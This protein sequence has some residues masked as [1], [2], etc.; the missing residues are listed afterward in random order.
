[1]KVKTRVKKSKMRDFSRFS[2]DILNADLSN[3]DWS[4]LFANDSNDVNSIFSSF[5]NKFNKLVN[6]HAPM[7]TISNR[8]AKQFSK[9][10]ITKG[11]RKSIRVKNKLYVS[12][13]RVKY[14]M[15]RNKICTLTRISKQQYY[16]KFFNDNLTNMKKTWEGINSI[17][18][19]KSNNS[20]PICSIK[21]PDDN[22]SISSN[23]NRIANILN[24]H[25]ASVGPKL[26]NKLPSVQRNYFDF[27][28][29][30]N[31]PDTSFAF[32]LVIPSEVKLE[33]SRIPNN[34]SHG[35][36]SCPT[37]I[38]KCSSNVISNT[39]AEIINLSISTGIYPNKLK[40]AKIVPIFKTDDNTDPSNYRP[41]S[42]LS[43]FNRI[44]ENLIF[45]RMES[46]IAQHNMLSPSQYGFR[47]TF[48]TQHAILDIVST[49]QTNMDQRLFSCGVFIDLKKAFD[50]VDHKILLHKLDHY[51]FRGVINKWFSSYLQGRTQ[52]TQIASYI[53]ARNDITC[54][55]PQGSVLGPLLFLIYI[56]DIQECS[57]KLKFF[58]FAD[59]TSIL[60]ADKN[61][62]SL[63]LIVNQ[64]LCKLYDWLTANKLTLNI[65]KSNFVI[66]SPV[67]RKSTYQPKIM[68]FDNEQNKNVALECKE[69]IKY[70]GI[71][72]DS[73]LTWKHHIDHI[74]IKIS[75]TIGLISK[76]RHFVPKHTLINIYR[77]LVASYLSYG[78]I[79]WGQACK[80]YLDKL[81]KLQ[82]GALRYIY[83]SDRNQHAIPLFS[84]E[85]A[86]CHSK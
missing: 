47:K 11:L 62:R 86:R 70:L 23:P 42:L 66:F 49:I 16:T 10:W 36:Y 45:K 84:T 7:K 65:K 54:G 33:I 83:F 30:S 46:F 27:L 22:N 56:N 77:S 34:K 18:A 37:Q 60:Y 39:L 59:D 29:R 1:M 4:A 2:S 8:K 82:K 26:A 5:Y 21:D 79:V 71:L 74:A 3:V 24:K 51:G 25:F 31:S 75:R 64:E 55:V 78:L 15:Y 68:I 61:L 40:M 58:L 85:P 9:P 48:S 41:I 19:R 81:F 20:K 13:D 57:E 12:G 76:I 53:S 43:N 32:D 28:S 80:S 6:K 52:T 63:E 73:H 50:T 17:L 38:L 72:I 35:L 44:F 67:Q 14:K 69:F